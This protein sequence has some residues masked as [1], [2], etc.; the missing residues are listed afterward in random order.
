MLQKSIFKKGMVL[1]VVLA[2]LFSFAGCGDSGKDTSGGKDTREKGTKSSEKEEPV[3]ISIWTQME[4]FTIDD[5]RDSIPYEKD[6]GY[7]E[8]K[9]GIKL[10][11]TQIPSEQREE[12]LQIMLSTNSLTDIIDGGSVYDIRPGELFAN[13]QIV[14]ISGFSEQAKNYL[15][16]LKQYPALKKNVMDDEGNILYFCDPC[17]E[18]EIGFSGGLMMRKDW[19]DKLGLE[20]PETVDGWLNVLRA[21]RDGDPNGNN[22]ADEIP[23]VGSRG[24]LNVLGNVTG[25]QQDFY[26]VGGGGGE[27]V[28]GPF[29][30]GYIERLKFMHTMFSEKLI[31]QNYLNMDGKMRDTWM[32]DDKAGSTLTGL[33]NMGRW[34]V[35]MKDHSTFLMWPVSNPKYNGTR[36]FDRTDITKLM[37]NGATYVSSQAEYPEKCVELLDYFF[38]EEGHKLARFG[39]EGITYDMVNG[40][41]KYTDLIMKNKDGLTPDDAVKKYIGIP[42]MKGMEDMRKIAQLALT[43]PAQRQANAITWTGTFDEKNNTSLPPA[44]MTPEESTEYANIMADVKT[45]IKESVN[46]FV[47]GHM[48]I[49]DEY[50]SFVSQLRKMGAERALEIQ[51]AAVKRWQERGGFDYKFA[52]KRAE[53]EYWDQLDFI[54][55]KG[56]DDIDPSLK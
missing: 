44:I 10:K 27:V 19:V 26:M 7:L 13:E 21:I 16:I 52:A 9:F 41:P 46:K 15:E 25:I 56:I 32:L 29:E 47:Q 39:V 35:T 45:Y 1:A 11:I 5:R 8:D 53:I 38:G 37:R 3:E 18:L 22:E 24:T 33:G 17:I 40:L 55:E 14:P 4:R 20:M 23:F 28:F 34:N 36:Y 50:D 54:I 2:M 31:N 42:A 51:R 49:E 43:T 48:S 12:A 6:I 30:D